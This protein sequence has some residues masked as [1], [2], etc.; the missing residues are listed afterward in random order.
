[1]SRGNNVWSAP[2]G[3][4]AT[5]VDAFS[6]NLISSGA[7]ISI[8]IISIRVCAKITRMKPRRAYAYVTICTGM[9][10]QQTLVSV[11]TIR[12]VSLSKILIYRHA[13]SVLLGVNVILL[14]AIHV[15]LQCSE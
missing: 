3:A 9:I 7:S 6:A 11:I 1:M 10:E 4:F 13:R 12:L 14:D 8:R 2:K 5:I 15:I